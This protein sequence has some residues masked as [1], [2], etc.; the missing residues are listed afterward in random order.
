MERHSRIRAP[1][2]T[3]AEAPA[4][5]GFC[6]E[7]F[8]FEQTSCFKAGFIRKRRYLQ[9]NLNSFSPIVFVVIVAALGI[10]R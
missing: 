5:A 2:M 7:V 9:S 3:S 1:G 6:F 10:H 8:A 4:P